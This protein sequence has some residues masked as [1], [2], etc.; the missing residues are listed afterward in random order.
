MLHIHK[1][2]CI[3]VRS[4]ITQAH[5][6]TT[7]ISSV[8]TTCVDN[9]DYHK[10]PISAALKSAFDLAYYFTGGPAGT[11][12]RVGGAVFRYTVEIT[13]AYSIETLTA[14]GPITEN[15]IVEVCECEYVCV[16]TSQIYVSTKVC[17]FIDN[18][19]LKLTVLC[20]L[21][22]LQLLDVEHSTPKVDYT[23]H[24]PTQGSTSD[25]SHGAEHNPIDLNSSTPGN[26]DDAVYMW[27][28]TPFSPCSVSCGTGLQTAHTRCRDA[29]YPDREIPDDF[30]LARDLPMLLPIQQKCNTN[31]CPPR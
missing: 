31:A 27:K 3:V 16:T 19:C 4:F 2:S 13:G 26:E 20:S 6:H 5:L 11:Y 12:H 24:L 18:R 25:E 7:R 10:W 15:I 14:Q 8:F 17:C 23:Y 28:Y 29:Q 1:G 30:C 9:T 22:S 21:P